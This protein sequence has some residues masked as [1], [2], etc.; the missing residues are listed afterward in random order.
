[1][2]NSSVPAQTWV[3]RL[4]VRWIRRNYQQ[5]VVYIAFVGVFIAFGV[6]QSSNGF[7]STQNLL[8]IVS[9]TAAISVMAVAVT[10]VIASA[11]IDLSVGSVV[12]LSSVT[13]ALAMARWGLVAGLL[14]GVATGLI[15]GLVNGLLVTRIGIPSFLVTLGMLGIA[16]G[17][18]QWIT[19]SAAVPI[20]NDTFNN[21]FGGGKV[22][23]LSILVIWSAVALVIGH[24]VL[25][26]TKYGRQV[27]ATGG[28]EVAARFSG[29]N[30]R[31]IKLK[32]LVVSG[33]AAALAGMLDAGRL[34]TGRFQLGQ[35]DEL[36]VIAAVIVGGNSLFGGVGSVVGAV[37][38]SVL[39]SMI[40]NGLIL[41]G[42]PFSQQVII[43]GVIIILAVA[44]AG[45][46][47]AG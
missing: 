3:D 13:T 44:L 42:L 28:N 37:V 2:A 43:R 38:G 14:A 29:I 34:Q 6:T 45:K 23:P 18:A 15:V 12:G 33:F 31:N 16:S 21:I 36:S 26:K 19:D 47:R 10:F 7:L 8:N 1:M 41:M 17:T 11:E 27:L 46:R 40:N 25:K 32:V 4:G 39:I 5:Y 20:S 30:T 22:G 35:G 24:V 9:Q